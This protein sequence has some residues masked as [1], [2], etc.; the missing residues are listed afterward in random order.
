MDLQPVIVSIRDC[1]LTRI[2]KVLVIG[3]SLVLLAGDLQALI[4][5][6]MIIFGR[7]GASITMNIFHRIN[8]G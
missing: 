6:R 3:L 1:R 5:P 4:Y 8:L 7:Q 2:D